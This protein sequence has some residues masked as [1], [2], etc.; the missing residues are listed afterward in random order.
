MEKNTTCNTISHSGV[1]K[2]VALRQKYIKKITKI[3]KKTVKKHNRADK[4][5]LYQYV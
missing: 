2:R 3:Q 4:R 1:A 5:A